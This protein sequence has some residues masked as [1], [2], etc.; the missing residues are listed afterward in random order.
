MS[1]N[2]S[3][4][5]FH[6]GDAQFGPLDICGSD[7]TQEFA[8]HITRGFTNQLVNFRLLNIF[9]DITSDPYTPSDPGLF[10]YVGLTDWNDNPIVT[11]YTFDMTQGN[12]DLKFLV[13]ASGFGRREPNIKYYAKVMIEALIQQEAHDHLIPTDP[14]TI[15]LL[16]TGIGVEMVLSVEFNAWTSSVIETDPKSLDFDIV[17]VPDLKELQIVISNVGSAPSTINK[18]KIADVFNNDMPQYSVFLNIPFILNP[19]NSV[20]LKVTFN[21]DSA[22]TFDGNLIIYTGEM[23]P[24]CSYALLIPIKGSAKCSKLIYIRERALDFGRTEAHITKNI[25]IT[26]TRELNIPFKIEKVRFIDFLGN[27]VSQYSAEL[28]NSDISPGIITVLPITFTPDTAGY[29]RARAVLIANKR[30]NNCEKETYIPLSGFGLCC[31]LV[32]RPESLDFGNVYVWERKTKPV[33]LSNRGLATIIVKKILIEHYFPD[34]INMKIYEVR[35]IEDSNHNLVNIPF[36]INPK[37]DYKLYITCRPLS[38]NYNNNGKL[39]LKISPLLKYCPRREID[40]KVEP[41]R[42]RY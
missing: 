9:F 36:E 12:M 8:L 5:E 4:E 16:Y 21:P 28:S 18:I 42:R 17:T 22:G 24:N 1:W 23:L 15:S 2:I 38:E 11:P 32:I 7:E 39:I 19:G 10:E 29:C 40:L 27:N 20:N 41:K 25:R 35:K 31:R 14:P 33:I 37:E 13:R 34:N 3:G 30:V 26:H 6:T